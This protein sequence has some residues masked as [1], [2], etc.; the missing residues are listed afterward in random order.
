MPTPQQILA[1]TGN[2]ANEWRAVAIGW[3]VALAIALVALALG[4]RP[5]V[6]TATRK[7]PSTR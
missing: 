2:V 6:R 7:P 5:A 3:H 4:W 1:V